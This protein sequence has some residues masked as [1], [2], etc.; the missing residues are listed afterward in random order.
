MEASGAA[1]PEKALAI[2]VTRQMLYEDEAPLVG[3]GLVYKPHYISM[4]PFSAA[5]M[6]LHV[7][8]MASS[9]A[10]S[11]DKLASSQLLFVGLS[12]MSSVLPMVVQHP[13]LLDVAS[14]ET[15]MKTDEPLAPLQF[16]GFRLHTVWTQ[17]PGEDLVRQV[18]FPRFL[19]K[20]T[21][22]MLEY[23]PERIPQE[24]TQ[25]QKMAVNLRP[26]SN[27]HWNIVSDLILPLIQGTLRQRREAKQVALHQEERSEGAEASPKE[28]SAPGKSLQVEAEGSGEAPPGGSALPRQRV[29]ETTQEI[30]AHIHTLCLQTMHEMGSVRELDHG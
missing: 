22:P 11:E 6:H 10:E 2:A 18:A 1:T 26:P 23:E 25:G 21:S 14:R 16:R 8:H 24:L 20:A 27:D 13:I 17:Q 19:G 30:L 4:E 29:I 12:E 15:L 28:V 5:Y 7:W 9:Q 3:V